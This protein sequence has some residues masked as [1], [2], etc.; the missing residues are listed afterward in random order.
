MYL[1]RTFNLQMNKNNFNSLKF[2][3]K[4]SRS[5]FKIEDIDNIKILNIKDSKDLTKKFFSI[6]FK[7]HKK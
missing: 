2:K 1:L 6:K 4:N 5:S 3:K 7:F